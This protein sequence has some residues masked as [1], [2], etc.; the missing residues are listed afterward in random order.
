MYLCYIFPHVKDDDFSNSPFDSSSC[1]YLDDLFVNSIDLEGR[2]GFNSPCMWLAALCHCPERNVEYFHSRVGKQ[3]SAECTQPV[4]GL[5]RRAWQFQPQLDLICVVVAIDY[6]IKAVNMYL[7]AVLCVDNMAKLWGGTCHNHSFE[8]P[9][10][11]S[12]RFSK[13]W[14]HHAIKHLY[15]LYIDL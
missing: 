3:L 8:H 15:I 13:W 5:S 7:S 6:C 12:R 2:F 14:C 10:W 1:T 9:D 4:N 11:D